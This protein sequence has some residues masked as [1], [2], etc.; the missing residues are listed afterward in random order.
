MSSVRAWRLAVGQPCADQPTASV[1]VSAARLQR[2]LIREESNELADAIRW[3]AD[4]DA[5]GFGHIIAEKSLASIA[6][7]IGDLVFVTIG[8]AELYGLDWQ[9]ILDE[10]TRANMR[11]LVNGKPILNAAGKV[12]KPADWQPPD[13]AAVINAMRAL[14]RNG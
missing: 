3:Q 1:D 14:G 7:E 5:S 6:H 10:T 13:W 8:A 2:N 9:R 11:K 4:W 12:Q